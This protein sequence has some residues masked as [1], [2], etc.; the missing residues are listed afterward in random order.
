MP[1]RYVSVPDD[2]ARPRPLRVEVK[3]YSRKEG[4]N[5]I[6][7][8]REIEMA[9]RS[10]LIKLDHQQVSLA[11]LKLDGRARERAWTCST[12]VDLAFP[13]WESL[14]SQ[15]VQVFSPPNQAYRVRSRFYQPAR[16]D[17][18]PESVHVT[19][20]IEGLRTGVA[21]TEVFRVHP[22]TFEEAVRIALNAEHNFKSARLGWN[23]YNPSS[24]RA[25]YTSTP[26]GNRPEPMD[27]SYAE[28]ER[29]AELQASE[30]Q[31]VT[32]PGYE[33]TLYPEPEVWHGTGKCRHPV[34]AG[35]LRGKN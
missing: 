22:S 11:T 7:W 31:R 12:S 4:E 34:G 6:L 35:A 17:P 33:P 27:L 30:Q 18:L 32:A 9:M 19:I 13:T 8:I 2:E 25:N 29:E 1:T 23:G 21:R 3:N 14:K 26:V 24:A 28:D 16:P 10:G 20:F 15:L 5:L